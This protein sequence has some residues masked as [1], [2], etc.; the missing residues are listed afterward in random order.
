[1]KTHKILEL[2]HWVSSP[3]QSN[4]N[5]FING[6]CIEA[7]NMEKIHEGNSKEYNY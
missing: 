1:M 6:L 7:T 3:H 4:S 2:D 5:W